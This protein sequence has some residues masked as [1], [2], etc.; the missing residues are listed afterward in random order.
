MSGADGIRESAPGPGVLRWELCNEARRNAVSPAA[1][2]F[3]AERAAAL[4]GET[5]L[6]TGRGD[7]AFCSGFD[8]TALRARGGASEPPDQ[9][10]IE[11]TAAMTE[12]N[13]TF[14]AVLGGY[15]IG[16]GVELACACDFRLAH[17]HVTFEIPAARLGVVYHARGLARL[18]AVFGPTLTRRLVLL[19]HRIDTAAAWRAGALVERVAPEDLPAATER[20]VAD[21]QRGDPASARANRELLRALDAGA[22]DEAALARHA[23]ARARAYAEL[24]PC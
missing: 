17:E 21:V 7:E 12:A 5:V 13:A 9:A 20:I 2:A 6:L 8:L 3:M 15:A 19:G 16:A 1:L 11:A 4:R 22:P 24:D 23:Q 10:L 14:I 18:R